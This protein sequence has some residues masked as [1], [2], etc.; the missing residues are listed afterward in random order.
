MVFSK[1]NID[2]RKWKID[3]EAT[4]YT[5][6]ENWAVSFYNFTFKVSLCLWITDF[7]VF[8]LIDL[9]KTLY[10]LQPYCIVCFVW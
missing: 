5:G 1:E 2:L 4:T 10:I 7:F 9:L 8:V 6:K 3:N